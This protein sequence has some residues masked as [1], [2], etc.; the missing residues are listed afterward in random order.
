MD[1]FKTDLLV[2]FRTRVKSAIPSIF[3]A[4]VLA[5]TS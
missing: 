2:S 1:S 5:W 3:A 4:F